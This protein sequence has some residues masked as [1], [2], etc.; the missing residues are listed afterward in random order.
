MTP[1]CEKLALIIA[2]HVW[3]LSRLVA[4][5]DSNIIPWRD[6]EAFENKLT[7]FGMETKERKTISLVWYSGS[8]VLFVRL[9]WKKR[10][11]FGL[12]L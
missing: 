6:I 7:N 12:S 9:K 1:P 11:Q 3:V 5:I 10:I 2:E 4:K 8:N